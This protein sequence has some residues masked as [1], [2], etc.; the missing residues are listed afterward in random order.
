MASKRYANQSSSTLQRREFGHSLRKDFLFDEDWINL[1]HGMLVL[2]SGPLFNR[3]FGF[4]LV[5]S[6]VVMCLNL[7]VSTRVDD[8]DYVLTVFFAGLYKG[9]N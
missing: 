8:M 9:M 2:L 4:P 5:Y 7:F 1:N 6:S 3:A